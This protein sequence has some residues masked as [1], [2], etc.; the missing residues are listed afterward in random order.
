MLWLEVKV[1]FK[2]QDRQLAVDL[3]SDAFYELDIKGVVVEGPVVMTGDDDWAQAPPAIIQDG[4]TGYFPDD[5]QGA[6]KCRLLENKLKVLQ[7]RSNIQTKIVYQ[8][9]DEEDWAE[10]WK[11]YFG[12]ERISN[13]IV[14]KPSWREYQARKGDLIIEIDP[15]MAFGT[16]THPSTVLCVQLLEK[17]LRPDH[18]FLDVVPAFSC[19]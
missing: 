7:A 9:L 2:H 14:I 13:N 1:F 3:I 17:Y 15:G 18:S 4:V 16:G 12:P 11:T 10:S 5:A 6:R 8:H 19:W